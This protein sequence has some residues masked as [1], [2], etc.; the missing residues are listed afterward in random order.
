MGIEQ[1]PTTDDGHNELREVV[2]DFLDKN[3]S[4]EDVRAAMA[5]TEGFDREVWRGLSQMELPAL[6][7]PD[8]YVG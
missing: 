7:I 1:S 2:R 5:T 4:E 3:S 8:S 6:C